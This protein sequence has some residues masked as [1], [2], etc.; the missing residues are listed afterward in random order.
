[1]RII[2][3]FHD[4]YDCIQRWGQDRTI[5]YLR[6]QKDI[7]KEWPF[8]GCQGGHGGEWEKPLCRVRVIGFCG[9][10]IP[11]LDLY[12]HSD[13]QPV[14]CWSIEDVDQFMHIN[15]NKG[16]LRAY[17]SNRWVRGYVSSRRRSFFEKFFIA[18]GYERDSYEYLFRD[19]HSP[20]FVAGR[21]RIVFNA[22]LKEVEF[23][24]QFDSY[25]AFQEIAIYMG[26]VLGTHGGHKTK[27]KGELMSSE[28]SD[29]DLAAAKGFDKHSFRSS[30]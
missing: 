6:K 15:L 14:H 3:D 30:G 1:M 17:K 11:M 24:K 9:K 2:S 5:V 28:V 19:H 7:K 25:R 12:A 10:I 16:E 26:G 21:G 18:C 29:R 20:V 27:Y 13:A 4:Y 8:P 22:C 23:Y